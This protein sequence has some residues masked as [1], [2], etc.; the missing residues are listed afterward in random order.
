MKE[1]VIEF[2]TDQKQA[3]LTLSQR[4]YITK[5]EKLAQDH[6]D[7]CIIE[8]RNKDGSICAVVPVS[9]VK[10]SPTRQ[11]SEEQKKACAERL[12][13]LKAQSTLNN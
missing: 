2:L 5:I 8:A 4:R 13:N 9:W 3:T 10:V 1:N 7:E 6:P 12:R 11:M